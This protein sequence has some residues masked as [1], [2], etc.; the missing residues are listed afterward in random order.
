MGVDLNAG[1]P[2][3]VRIEHI[4]TGWSLWGSIVAA[5]GSCFRL[6]RSARDCGAAVP[7]SYLTL[8]SWSA[9]AR[10]QSERS[11]RSGVWH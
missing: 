10:S 5:T 7:R 1:L 2:C 9:T 8:Q 4:R 3:P 6:C 11:Y